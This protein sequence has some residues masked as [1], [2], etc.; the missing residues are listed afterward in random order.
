[1]TSRRTMDPLLLLGSIIIVAVALTWVIP[2]GQY[3]RSPDPQSGKIQV[4]PGS[5]KRV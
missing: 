1:M 5:Y 4:V 3:E 2:A